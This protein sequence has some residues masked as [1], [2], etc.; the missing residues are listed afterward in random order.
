MSSW[1][2]I[3]GH[4]VC[5]DSYIVSSSQTHLIQATTWTSAEDIFREK[6]LDAELERWGDLSH[7][8]SGEAVFIEYTY[9][10]GNGKPLCL[11]NP[12]RQFP[13]PISLSELRRNTNPII[14]GQRGMGKSSQVGSPLWSMRITFG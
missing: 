7:L 4:A 14:F 6:V 3:I 1:W 2:I 10:C 5:C 9:L 11:R 8:R 13:K 12:N